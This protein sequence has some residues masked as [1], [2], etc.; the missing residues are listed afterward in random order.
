MAEPEAV[1]TTERWFIRQGLPLFVEEYSAGRD[2][3]TRAVPVLSFLFVVNILA[4][5]TVARSVLGGVLLALVVVAALAAYGAVNVRAGRA[6]YALPQ[7]LG[8]GWLAAFVVVPPLLSVAVDHDLQLFVGSLLGGLLLLGLVYVV[9]RYALVAQVG[10]ALRWTFR[11]LS[12][13][14]KLITS[15]LPL[16]LLFITFL[17]INTEVWQVAGTMSAAVLWGSLAVF[18][19]VGVLFIVGRSRAE[20]ADIEVSTDTEHVRRLTLGTPM[21]EAAAGLEGLEQPVPLRRSQRANLVAVM[22]TAQSVQVA[23]VGVVVW[24]FFVL[25]GSVAISVAVQEAWLAGLAPVEVLVQLGPGHGITRQLLRVSTF[26]GGFAGFYATVYAASDD[27]YRENFVAR[28]SATV[29]RAVAVRRAYV[30]LRRREGLP[31]DVPPERH[32]ASLHPHDELDA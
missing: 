10:W 30:A 31:V 28:I 5:I 22:V 16:M 9:T 7:Q 3:W 21:Q 15:V 25:F 14:T 1:R 23:L 24:A 17:F 19:I 12:S 20:F 2:V 27:V 11:Q 18:A 6:W 26:L 13:V 29:E 8:F 32:P 4:S